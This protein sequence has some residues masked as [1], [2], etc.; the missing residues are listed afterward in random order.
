MTEIFKTKV[1]PVAQVEAPITPGPVQ[2]E[3]KPIESREQG[4][5]ENEVKRIDIY[6]T[7]K[8]H[9]YAEDYFGFRELIAGDFKLKMDISKI[10]K[11]IKGEIEDKSYDKTLNVYRNLL[12][13]ME[14]LLKSNILNPRAR[15]QKIVNWIGVVGKIKNAENLKKTLLET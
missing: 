7:E 11:F 1:E 9:K 13:E 6:E 4:T 15:L 3:A 12:S 10:D 2:P 8:G 5:T 14:G